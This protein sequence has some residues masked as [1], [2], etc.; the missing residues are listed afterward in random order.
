MS[1]INGRLVRLHGL[2]PAEIML[3]FVLEWRLR[4]KGDTSEVMQGFIEEVMQGNVNEI[5]KGPERFIIQRLVDKKDK[6]K[7]FFF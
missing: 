7:I 3:S 4:H 5:E 2:I 6:Q 1:L